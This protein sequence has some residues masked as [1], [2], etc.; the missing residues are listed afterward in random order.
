MT[1]TAR[2][3]PSVAPGQGRR[4]DGYNLIEMMFVMG[5]MSVLAAMAVVQINASRA[6][7]KGDAA[8]RVVMTQMNQAR[9]MAITQRRYMQVT[10]TTPRT[11]NIVRED[12]T[13]TTTKL[14]SV[15]FEGGATFGVYTGLPDTPDAFGKTAATYFTSSAGVVTTVKFAPDGTLVDANGQTAN[16]SVFLSIPT[17]VLSS[18]AVTVLGST[19]RVRAYRWDGSGWK[20]V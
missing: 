15:P 13:A 8:M 20:V 16:G 2:I 17:M 4:D 10:F 5:I 3:P 18:R 6:A 7:L 19:G 11:V 1:G 12:T 9:E 14:S